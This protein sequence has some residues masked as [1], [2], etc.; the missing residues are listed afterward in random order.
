MTEPIEGMTRH[1]P[2][3]EDPSCHGYYRE[4]GGE[5]VNKA[6]LKESKWEVDIA[7]KR[8]PAEVSLRPMFDPKMERIKT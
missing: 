3:I 4:E 5:P 6:Y 1:L 2:I 7:G 8:Y